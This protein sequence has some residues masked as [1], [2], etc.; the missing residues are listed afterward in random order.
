MAL[1]TDTVSE[2]LPVPVPRPLARVGFPGMVKSVVTAATD[3][4]K[5]ISESVTQLTDFPQQLVDGVD[6][7][8]QFLQ[9]LDRMTGQILERME[10]LL[11]QARTMD[12][13]AQEMVAAMPEAIDQ[14]RATNVALEDA[15]VEIAGLGTRLDRFEQIAERMAQ[16]EV[17]IAKTNEHL[18]GMLKLAQPFGDAQEAAQRF[19]DSFRF[20]SRRRKGSSSERQEPPNG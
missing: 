9:R 5:A 17:Q 3:A 14:L 18:V 11:G 10:A 16:M 6:R 19:R 7:G 20:G 1:G 13:H 2:Y 4:A 8:V 15:R 12:D